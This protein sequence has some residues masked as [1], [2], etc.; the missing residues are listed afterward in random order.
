MSD[1]HSV[2]DPV[3]RARGE[4]DARTSRRCGLVVWYAGRRIDV[5]SDEMQ[6]IC[7][8]KAKDARGK[9]VS[10]VLACAGTDVGGMVGQRVALKNS[11]KAALLVVSAFGTADS[12]GYML[13]QP[14]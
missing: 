8:V 13:C 14:C 6:R 11:A 5:W 12:E 9:L 7:G 2:S 3:T 4:K 10:D 1:P